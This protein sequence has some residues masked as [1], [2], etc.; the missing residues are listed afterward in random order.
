MRTLGSESNEVAQTQDNTPTTR[1]SDT[2][3][4]DRPNASRRVVCLFVASGPSLV[5]GLMLL[6]ELGWIRF[7]HLRPLQKFHP[8]EAP[9]GYYAYG[10]TLLGRE[11]HTDPAVG[12]EKGAHHDHI[13]APQQRNRCDTSSDIT[14]RAI[15]SFTV[16]AMSLADC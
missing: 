10:K 1:V 9:K 6:N 15:V 16:H 12:C 11:R 13:H 5:D 4:E 3:Q 7:F 2:G 14:M 8:P